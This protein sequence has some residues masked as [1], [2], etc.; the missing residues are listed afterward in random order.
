MIQ[1]HIK[2]RDK[3]RFYATRLSVLDVLANLAAALRNNVSYIL[4]RPYLDAYNIDP[5][6]NFPVIRVTANSYGVSD[7]DSVEI[8]FFGG[9]EHFT[10]GEISDRFPPS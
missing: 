2:Y 9:S 7:Q 1:V 8:M 3:E 5:N 10:L 6:A 4:I